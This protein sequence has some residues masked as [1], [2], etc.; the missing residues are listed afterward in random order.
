MVEEQNRLEIIL[1]CIEDLESAVRAAIGY[2]PALLDLE[3]AAQYLNLKESY[4]N[5]LRRGVDGPPYIKVGDSVRY[6]VEDLDN[7][8]RAQTRRGRVGKEA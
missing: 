8:L 4:L 1:A 3:A 7:W 6:P 5:K 2:K